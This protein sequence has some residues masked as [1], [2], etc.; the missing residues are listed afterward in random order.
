M[1][2]AGFYPIETRQ[3]CF[4]KDGRWY[5]D[6]EPVEHERLARLFSRHLRRKPDGS[7]YE[8]WIDERYHADVVVEDTPF[9]VVGVNL[10]DGAAGSLTLNDGGEEELD[11]D[12][13]EV[14]EGEVLYCR[15]RQ[16]SERARFLRSAYYQ[17]VPHLEETAEGG[18]ALRL[19]DRL[20][21]IRG[22][23]LR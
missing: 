7:G 2:G 22:R 1:A 4:R 19:G 12:S 17:L 14:G 13:L 16:G 21:P 23:Q 15:V 8:I 10:G 5:A 9:V 11:A 20:H 3:L 6:D 18:F